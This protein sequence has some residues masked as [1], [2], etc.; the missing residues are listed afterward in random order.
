MGIAVKYAQHEY[1]VQVGVHEDFREARAVRSQGRVVDPQAVASILDNHRLRDQIVDHIR[2]LELRPI[3]ECRYE[4]SDVSRL[5]A[6]IDL[7]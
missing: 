2:N 7:L 4:G 3:R 6:E 5:A 1:L